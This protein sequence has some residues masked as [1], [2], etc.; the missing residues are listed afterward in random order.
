MSKEPTMRNAEQVCT[1]GHH[2]L[3]ITDKL[4][5]MWGTMPAGGEYYEE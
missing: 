5:A 1:F 3:K 2:N 4:E